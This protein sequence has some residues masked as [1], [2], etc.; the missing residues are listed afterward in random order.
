M[1]L[2]SRTPVVEG[3][4]KVGSRI[5]VKDVPELFEEFMSLVSSTVFFDGLRAEILSLAEV[6]AASDACR[7]DALWVEDA[8]AAIAVDAA[9]SLDAAAGAATNE[10]LTS[11]EGAVGGVMVYERGTGIYVPRSITHEYEGGRVDTQTVLGEVIGYVKISRGASKVLGEFGDFVLLNVPQQSGAEHPEYG[12]GG[13]SRVAELDSELQVRVK[14]LVRVTH[15]LIGDSALA[16]SSVESVGE[17]TRRKHGKRRVVKRGY[18]VRTVRVGADLLA[19]SAPGVAEAAEGKS[20]EGKKWT[21]DHRVVTRGHW[22]QVAY[23]KNRKLR[24]ARWIMPYVRG[25]EGAPLVSRPVVKVWRG[26][27]GVG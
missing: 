22:R 7:G 19:S 25:P 20:S 5:A 15:L 21:L 1:G 16:H 3:V 26:G 13:F 18:P 9:Q 17:V 6:A 8:M 24:R 23:G 14:N 10:A 27:G 12:L 2:S 11:W 4:R